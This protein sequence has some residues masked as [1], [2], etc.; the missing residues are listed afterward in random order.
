[1]LDYGVKIQ[2]T[3]GREKNARVPVRHFVI[4]NAINSH[5]Q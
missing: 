4:E 2:D 3:G 5:L 1:L